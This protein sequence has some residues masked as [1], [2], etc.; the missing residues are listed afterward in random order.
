MVKINEVYN[1]DVFIT[2]KRLKDKSVNLIICDSPYYKIKGG[3][4][5]AFKAMQEWI[6]WHIKL[7]DEFERVLADN[8]SL[9]VFG[10]EKNIAYLQV[11][12]DKK[13][14]LLNSIVYKKV[15]AL[16]IKGMMDFNMFAPVTERI[17]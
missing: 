17:F 5:W 8:G 4:D 15:N 3:F 13:F 16:T 10:D 1:E 7:R 2:L 12:F 11:E 6:D 9:F 14:N